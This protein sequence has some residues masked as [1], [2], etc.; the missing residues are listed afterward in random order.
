MS[1]GFFRLFAWESILAMILLSLESWFRDPFSLYQIISWLLLII[2]TVLVVQGAHHLRA[3]GKPDS[4]R[5]DGRLMGI[6]KTTALVTL[7]A[8]KYIRHPLYSSLLCLG[9]GVFFKNLSWITATLATM[10]TA[11]LIATAKMEEAENIRFFGP[12]YAAYMKQTKMFI[13][14]IF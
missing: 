3:F 10:T 12:D 6:E 7:G 13:P 8:Y 14:F 11:F 4:T 9:W 2:S 5:Q 1:H